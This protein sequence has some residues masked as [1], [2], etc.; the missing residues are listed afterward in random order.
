MNTYK[1]LLTAAAAWHV[2]SGCSYSVPPEPT[3]Q[4]DK[5]APLV[6][7]GEIRIEETVEDAWRIMVDVRRWPS[8]NPDITEIRLSGPLSAG[9]E[10]SWKSGLGTIRSRM[11]V[12]EPPCV[13]T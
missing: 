6:A 4:I 13:L 1:L 9:T 5:N 3:G 12:L 8:W 7:S 2:L 10:F 11:Q